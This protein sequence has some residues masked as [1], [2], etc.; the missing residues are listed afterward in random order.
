MARTAVISLDG[1]EYTIHAFNI[2]ELE[3][4]TVAFENERA[5][6]PYKVLRIALRRAEPQL[7]GSL[8]D[9][10]P[11]AGEVLE[12][13]RTIVELSGMNMAGKDENPTPPAGPA[14]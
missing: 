6:V 12:A 3:E 2:G 14:G 7:N 4:A 11:K 8:E 9:I 13:F 5:R 10:E 1:K